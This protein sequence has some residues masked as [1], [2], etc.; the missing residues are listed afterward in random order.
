MFYHYFS[1][2]TRQHGNSEE[3]ENGKRM[4]NQAGN[5]SEKKCEENDDNI[6]FIKQQ[7]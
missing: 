3:K 7:L 2:P 5:R 4:E 6:N 1:S